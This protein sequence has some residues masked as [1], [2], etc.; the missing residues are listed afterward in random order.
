MLKDVFEEYLCS[1]IALIQK[2]DFEEYL[3]SIIHVALILRIL[4]GDFEEYPRVCVQGGG[5][6]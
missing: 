2:S 5:G 1:V 6:T 4:K 3:W